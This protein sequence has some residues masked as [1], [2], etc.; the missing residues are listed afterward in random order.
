MD[1]LEFGAAGI[2]PVDKLTY[3]AQAST[4]GQVYSGPEYISAIPFIVSARNKVYRAAFL[5]EHKLQFKPN[6]FIKD[7][8]FNIKALFLSQRVMAT[9]TLCT[10]FL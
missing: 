1:I 6:M 9:G 7:V 10:Q 5:K 3:T 2:T 4:H 8:E